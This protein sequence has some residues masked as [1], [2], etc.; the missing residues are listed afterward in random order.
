[1]HFAPRK[2]PSCRSPR[3]VALWALSRI[4]NSF[5][6]P[7]SGPDLGE[8]RAFR[9]DLRLAQKRSCFYRLYGGGGSH[10]RTT[11]PAFREKYREL[12]FQDIS[13]VLVSRVFGAVAT[14]FRILGSNWNR[15]EQGI[16]REFDSGESEAVNAAIR[17]AR[18]GRPEKDGTSRKSLVQSSSA[19]STGKSAG[20]YRWTDVQAFDGDT[21]AVRCSMFLTDR[22][23]RNNP[24]RLVVG[25]ASS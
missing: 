10:V 1:L 5:S 13:K 16:S 2:G 15:E 20:V 7:F 18:S 25:F 9:L 4:R 24:A 11:L 21:G 3:E 12:V 14:R 17:A 22:Q 23:L 8:M 6:S 19:D